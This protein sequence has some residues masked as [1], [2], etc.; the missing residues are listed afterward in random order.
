MN[1]YQKEYIRRINNVIDYV[2]Q[3]L[4]SDLSLTKLSEVANF[5]AFHFHRIFSVF[6]GETLNGFIK[7]KRVETAGRLL[8]NNLEM[9]VNEIAYQCGFNSVSVFC[10]NFKDHFKMSAQEFRENW[11]IEKS[12]NGQSNSKNNK[13]IASGDDYVCDVNSLKKGDSI[14]KKKIEVKEMPAL[15][16][17]YCRHMGDFNLIGQ[18]YAKLMKWAGPRGL[19]SSPDVKTVTVYHDDPSVTEID[20]VRQS[21]C[22]TVNED[23]KTEGE[24]GNMSLPTGKYVVGNFEIS[25]TE[26]TEA[27]NAVC[28]WLSESGYQ[29]ADGHPYELYHNNHEEH[30][31]K[32]FILDICIPVKPM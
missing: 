9:P 18:A 6:T 29:P 1:K 27:W 22:I 14:M 11:E 28:V 13:L 2:E 24:F 4:N 25:V 16:L 5:S 3:N 15:N 32:K 10:R 7:R 30:P 23:V 17:V 26:F 21:A 31:E 12:K 20:K 8:L 19:L